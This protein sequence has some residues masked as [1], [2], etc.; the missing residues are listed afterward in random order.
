VSGR[1]AWIV[2]AIGFWLAAGVVGAADEKP[3]YVGAN[4]CRLCH[5]KELIGNQYGVWKEGK[6]AQ[7]FETLK[8][9][10]AL[11]IAKEKGI[12]VPPHEAE[13]C[14]KCHVTAY[15]E[16]PSKFARRPLAPQDGVQCESCHGPGSLYRKKKTMSDREKAVAAGLWEADKDDEICAACHNEDS[17]VVPEGGFD[18]GKLREGIQHP[19][20]EDVKGRYLE[21]EK[22]L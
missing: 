12:S 19:I 7:A 4:K 18:F 14:L 20:P 5:K 9:E 13:Q 22:Q 11:E 10:K 21:I 17:P 16:D 8:G 6:H 1:S 3:Q 15:G 2:V